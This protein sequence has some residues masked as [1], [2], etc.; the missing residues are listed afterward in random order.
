[1]AE[2]GRSRLQVSEDTISIL[3]PNSFGS[4]FYSVHLILKRIF[5]NSPVA[6]KDA[7]DNW[8]GN[9]CLSLHHLLGNN[10]SVVHK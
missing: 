9:I 4:F 7:F 1:M 10:I 6:R 2:S 3:S 8:C 5:C